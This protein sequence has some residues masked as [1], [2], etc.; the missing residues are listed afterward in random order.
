MFKSILVSTDGTTQSNHAIKA[1]AALA[2][3]LGATLTLFHASRTYHALY[4]PDGAGFAWPPQK[5]Y[6]KEAAADAD[7]VLTSARALAEKHGVKA[8][9]AQAS[10]DSPADAII[11]A[12]K[13]F[14][15]DLIVMASHGRRGLD[16]LLLGSETQK[17][18]AHT[19]H[20]VLVVR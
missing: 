14:K 10:S 9:T 7:K 19:K 3:D 5:Q 18:L 16:K 12:A 13:K 15:A 11:A 6:L 8:A 2:K 20:P 1:A 4:Y 17:V